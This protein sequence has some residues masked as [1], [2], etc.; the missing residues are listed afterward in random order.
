MMRRLWLA[1]V[2]GVIL[3]TGI[4]YT[5]VI[6]VASPSTNQ[7]PTQAFLVQRNTE[8]TDN[9]VQSEPQLALISIVLGI[10]IAA[11]VFLITKRRS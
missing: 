10:V 4:A 11:P 1:A 6:P 5:S 3:G 2:L 8:Q 9:R 7:P